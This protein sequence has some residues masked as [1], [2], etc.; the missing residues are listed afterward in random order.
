MAGGAAAAARRLAVPQR[1]DHVGPVHHAPPS[2]LV[3]LLAAAARRHLPDPDGPAEQFG[4]LARDASSA[5][6]RQVLAGGQRQHHLECGR[7]PGQ[8]LP[9]HQ[10][11]GSLGQRRDDQQRRVGLPA[12]R[13][14][15]M[16]PWIAASHRRDQRVRVG[17][18]AVPGHPDAQREREPPLPLRPP[19]RRRPGP[20]HAGHPPHPSWAGGELEMYRRQSCAVRL[21]PEVV[22]ATWTHCAGTRLSWVSTPVGELL[23]AL[24][25]GDQA[26]VPWG[27]RHRGLL[28]RRRFA[29]REHAQH[30]P[31]PRS[32]MTPC[33]FARSSATRPGPVPRPGWPTAKLP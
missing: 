9:G 20:G 10:P 13:K 24:R 19:R 15:S 12:P 17:Q 25:H 22:Q 27:E 26:P 18:L 1:D 30:V 14:R 33:P 3:G 7:R 11:V 23:V 31:G 5:K 28:E 6:S 29:D 8:H 32:A 21:C 16:S 2:P 4:E